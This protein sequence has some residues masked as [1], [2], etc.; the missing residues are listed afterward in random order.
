MRLSIIIPT[1]NEAGYLGETLRQARGHAVLA[2]PEIIVADCRSSDETVAVA[3]QL[4]VRVVC[5]EPP[6]QCRGAALNHGAAF[7]N[8][9]VLLFLDADTR[10]P[11]G[12]DA[13]I[14]ECL[15]DP[16]VVGG[17]FEFRLDGPGLGLR[18]VETINRIR[19][20]LW[21]LYY[22]DQG[23]FVRRDIFERVHG[24]PDRR[25]LEASDFCAALAA[26]GRLVLLRQPMTTSARRF[27]EGGLCRVFA[28]D[29]LIWALD[30][31]GG[32]TEVFGGSYQQSNRGRGLAAGTAANAKGRPLAGSGLPGAQR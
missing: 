31:V 13:A 12:Y 28:K 9:D 16:E 3:R 19:Y 7:A 30:L 8:G 15:H 2:P 6:P 4:G 25:I 5:A 11:P 17:A 26:H 18:I 27:R 1:L 32:P 22:G 20:R 23:I 21:R 29:I 24:Y 10:V 14:A